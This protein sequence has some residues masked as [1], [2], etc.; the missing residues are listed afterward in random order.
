MVDFNEVN[1]E[2]RT[3]LFY[4]YVAILF[5]FQVCNLN[6]TKYGKVTPSTS[7]IDFLPNINLKSL[8]T[9]NN[10]NCH[11]NYGTHVRYRNTHVINTSVLFILCYCLLLYS[12]D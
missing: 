7:N 10:L 11:P 1:E 3:S 8:A 12:I 2:V 6:C 9:T 4:H 5:I